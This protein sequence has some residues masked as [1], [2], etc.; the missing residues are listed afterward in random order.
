LPSS[1]SLEFN[2]T[3]AMFYPA[4]FVLWGALLAGNLRD[5]LRWASE[6]TGLPVVV[7]AAIALV[8]S[9]RIVRQTLRFA[10]QVALAAALLLGATKLG[11]LR[12]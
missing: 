12:W 8:A 3:G 6:H 7:V 5:G 2:R 9:W 10:L 4:R 1:A 11:L